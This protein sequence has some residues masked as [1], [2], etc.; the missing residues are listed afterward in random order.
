MLQMRVIARSGWGLLFLHPLES[1]RSSNHVVSIGTQP[2]RGG[3]WMPRSPPS[4]GQTSRGMIPKWF[5]CFWTRPNNRA[6]LGLWKGRLKKWALNDGYLWLPP[7][8]FMGFIYCT[9]LLR[10]ASL[11][12]RAH[13]LCLS[14]QYV[15]LM[16][17]VFD[18]SRIHMRSCAPWQYAPV[19]RGHGK[20][21]ASILLQERNAWFSRRWC[22]KCARPRKWQ[23]PSSRDLG[24]RYSWTGHEL[25]SPQREPPKLYTDASFVRAEQ[26]ASRIRRR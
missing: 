15:I 14:N 21:C 18:Q 22:W 17:F 23:R 7:Q 16:K 8:I 6:A 2:W 9:L 11:C 5:T 26:L 3:Y 10:L 25:E 4:R 13:P 1:G 12:G 24:A 19:Q 20:G